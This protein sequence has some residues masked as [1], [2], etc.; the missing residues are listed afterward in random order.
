MPISFRPAWVMITRRGFE[1]SRALISNEGD[2]WSYSIP[3]EKRSVTPFAFVPPI[4][5]P[6]GSTAVTVTVRPGST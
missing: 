6:S 1:G 2:S 3:L 5:F 4:G